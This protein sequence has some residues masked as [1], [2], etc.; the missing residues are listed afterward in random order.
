MDAELRELLRSMREDTRD[1]FKRMDDRFDQ[2]N[3]RVRKTEEAVAIL[4]DRDDQAEKHAHSAK[5]SGWISAISAIG[6][7]LGAAYAAWKS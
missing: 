6:T 5:R 2:M 1:G 7:L 4:N 3:G